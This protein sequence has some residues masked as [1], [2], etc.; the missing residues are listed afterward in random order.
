MIFPKM[1]LERTIGI[2]AV[3]KASKLCQSVFLSIQ[4]D[5]MSISKLDKSPVTIADFGAQA[6]V[7][8]LISSSFP[9]DKIVGTT[10][11]TKEK[12]IPKI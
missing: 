12:K 2:N 5:Q 8:Y 10:I 6:V 1:S 7:N 9:N 3:L 4:K 11:L